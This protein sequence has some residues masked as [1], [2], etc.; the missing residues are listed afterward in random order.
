MSKQKD[1]SSTASRHDDH[2]GKRA[3]KSKHLALR[4]DQQIVADTNTVFPQ[5][6]TADS[7]KLAARR[8]KD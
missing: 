8:R 6:S 4:A 1:N 2:P 3:E 7:K 5:H